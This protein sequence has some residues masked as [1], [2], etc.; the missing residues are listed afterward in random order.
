VT[1]IVLA[2]SLIDT[3]FTTTSHGD[4]P[5]VNTQAELERY[6]AGAQLEMNWPGGKIGLLNTD[7]PLDDN[8]SGSPNPT[9]NVLAFPLVS[10]SASDALAA[11]TG[12]D[13][14]AFTL[15]RDGGDTG[16][17]LTVYYT[18]GGKAEPLP[19]NWARIGLN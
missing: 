1:Q 2:D 15:S 13:P 5:A 10:V 17:P 16:S 11:E 8:I 14:A 6:A 9:F 18:L 3:T 19:V 12:I 7:Y 4:I